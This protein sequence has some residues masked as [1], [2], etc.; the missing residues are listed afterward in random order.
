[1]TVQIGKPLYPNAELDAEASVVDL[2]DRTRAA[3]LE[4]LRAARAVEDAGTP[5]LP[6]GT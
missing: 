6:L 1:V 5:S 4:M 3:V 2:R